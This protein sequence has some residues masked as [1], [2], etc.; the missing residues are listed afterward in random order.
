M[1]KKTK[2]CRICSNWK[3]KLT[4]KEKNNCY[5]AYKKAKAMQASS[6]GLNSS[7]ITTL[8][9][10]TRN[11]IGVYAQDEIKNLSV[12]Q[13]PSFLIINLDSISFGGSHWIAVGIFKAHIEIFDS[14]GFN[15]FNWP[16]IPC[17]LL[18]FLLKFSVGR[19]VLV[20]KRLQ[21]DNSTL[22]GL[23]CVFYVLARIT[24]R[25]SFIQNLFSD[26]LTRNDKVLI[27]LLK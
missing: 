25:F 21:S 13:Y 4:R 1:A 3:W 14:L 6:K 24:L 19:K 16:H 20:S 10:S 5:Q 11:F 7:E 18:N 9:S 17:D 8:L 26:N 2:R 23:Y 12:S 15:I 27:N 22:C